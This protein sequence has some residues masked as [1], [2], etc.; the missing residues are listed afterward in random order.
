MVMGVNCGQPVNS[1]IKYW[2]PSK[3]GTIKLTLCHHCGKIADKYVEYE[4]TLIVLDLILHR[5]G[6]YRHLL[7][8]RIYDEKI[9]FLEPRHGIYAPFI[10]L[11][12]VSLFMTILVRCNIYE[13]DH[14]SATKILSIS[15]LSISEF[16]VFIA[17]IF[18]AVNFYVKRNGYHLIM[19]NYLLMG[20]IISFFVKPSLILALIWKS[21]TYHFLTLIQTLVISSNIVA[22]KT[23][24]DADFFVSSLIVFFGYA[25]ELLYHFVVNFFCEILPM[26]QFL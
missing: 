2:G 7:F 14:L 11:L 13:V 25:C 19:W 24:T 8:N 1:V 9:P 17:G 5:I 18:F 23:F 4:L 15:F 16:F 26:N 10:K 21:H 12:A 6:V 20:V 3:S 22:I